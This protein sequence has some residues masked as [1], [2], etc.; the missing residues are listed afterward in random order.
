MKNQIPFPTE[1]H[2][3]HFVYDNLPFINP[4]HGQLHPI[5]WATVIDIS[6]IN[7]NDDD[8]DHFITPPSYY[9]QITPNG[10]VRGVTHD[11]DEH[12]EYFSVTADNFDVGFLK[13]FS[14]QFPQ[15]TPT[16]LAL[17][18]YRKYRT[19]KLREDLNQENISNDD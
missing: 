18:D 17:L 15:V 14:N 5:Q 3:D 4:E 10:E 16:L 1:N 6:L 11:F 12:E 9:L 2:K 19:S 13:V 8:D 7:P